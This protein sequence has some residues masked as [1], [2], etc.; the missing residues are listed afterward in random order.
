MQA[1]GQG[2]GMPR[3]LRLESE[4]GVYHVINRGNYRADVFRTDKTKA[5]FLKCVGDPKGSGLTVHYGGGR[6]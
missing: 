1:G 2:A 6:G 5:A 4:A 3:R